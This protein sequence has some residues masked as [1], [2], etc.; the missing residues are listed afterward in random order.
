MVTYWSRCHLR[1]VFCAMGHFKFL[2][3]IVDPLSWGEGGGSGVWTN[4][5]GLP[6]DDSSLFLEICLVNFLISSIIWKY[7]QLENCPC[8]KLPWKGEE[9]FVFQFLSNYFRFFY[10][11]AAITNCLGYGDW[12]ICWQV[13]IYY[14]F[15]ISFHLLILL[16]KSRTL[17]KANLITGLAKNWIARRKGRKEV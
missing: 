17:R 11:F 16:V 3:V 14:C 5:S 15:D 7:I 9:D 10:I 6:C 8:L 1:S 12:R 2:R 13:S 4:K